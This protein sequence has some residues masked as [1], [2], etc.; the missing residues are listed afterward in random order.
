MSTAPN[1]LAW[2]VSVQASEFLNREVVRKVGK[3][4]QSLFLAHAERRI[5]KEQIA[6]ARREACAAGTAKQHIMN[7]LP[8]SFD[9][10]DAYEEALVRAAIELGA[11]E[12]EA[13]AEVERLHMQLAAVDVR[14]A[15]HN[16][17]V[18]ELETR[19]RR[20]HELKTRFAALDSER[21]RLFGIALDALEPV[22]ASATPEVV[23][24][25]LCAWRSLYTQSFLDPSDE[26]G[27]EWTKLLHPSHAYLAAI[28]CLETLK[29]IKHFLHNI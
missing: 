22:M 16:Q 7:P 17:R 28:R 4:Q 1:T 21:R 8:L 18:Q 6:E 2:L 12:L 10:R 5:I 27:Y 23:S 15:R 9:E 29:E 3:Q 19:P 13:W 11:L 26:P 20:Y 25:R 24:E 14:I